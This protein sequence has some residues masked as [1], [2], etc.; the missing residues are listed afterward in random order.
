M[1]DRRQFSRVFATIFAL[2]L[3][4]AVATA[5]AASGAPATQFQTFKIGSY[6]A[7]ALKDGGLEV[8]VD[9]KS[10]VLD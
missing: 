3:P 8:P 4:L 6:T 9:G 7:V 2:S 1:R 5:D 10:F